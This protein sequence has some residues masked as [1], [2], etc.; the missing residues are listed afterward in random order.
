[1]WFG[2]GSAAWAL[3]DVGAATEALGQAIRMHHFCLCP[4]VRKV[5]QVSYCVKKNEPPHLLSTLLVSC[6]EQMKAG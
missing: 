3:S 4:T 5:K 1:V 2:G 6:L